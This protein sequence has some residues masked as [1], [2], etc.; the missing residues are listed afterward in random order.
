MPW[1]IAL[2]K[3]MT[4]KFK[5][6]FF[7]LLIAVL[8]GGFYYKDNIWGIYNNVGKNLQNFE[9][10][11]LGNIIN[12]FKKEVFTPSP[13]NIGGEANNVVMFKNQYFEHISPLGIGPAELV[14]SF[15]YDYIVTGE[16]LILGNFT[17]EQEV[18]QHWMDSPGHRANILNDRFTEIGVAVVKGNYK[19]QTV[20]ISVQEFGLPLSSCPEPS[21][22][23]K[24]QIDVNKNQLDLL[25]LKIE[26]KRNEINNTNSRSQKYNDL[27]DEYNKLVAEYNALN[28]QTKGIILEYNNQVNNF[29]QCVAGNN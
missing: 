19:G 21:A 17:G 27:V 10:T 29:N 25:F 23:L 20:W 9:K 28:T 4:T 18:V 13:L 1:K 7:I 2:Q 3:I 8:L 22:S 14:K 5:I 6:L 15:G 12:E 24:S 26:N 11:D 16:N